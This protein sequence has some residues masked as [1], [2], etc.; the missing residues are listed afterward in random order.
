MSVNATSQPSWFLRRFPWAEDPRAWWRRIAELVLFVAALLLLIFVRDVGTITRFALWI[1]AIGTGLFAAE[2][3]LGTFGPVLFYDML[4]SARRGRFVWLR[5]IYGGLLLFLL[6][7]SFLGS[8]YHVDMS[9]AQ[10]ESQLARNF[11]ET[12]SIVQFLVLSIL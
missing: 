4:R 10:A 5:A 9:A 12:F 6:F 8:R 7:V 11:F 2:G 1:L 3:W